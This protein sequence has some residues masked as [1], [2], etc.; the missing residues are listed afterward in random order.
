[1]MPLQLFANANFTGTN[2]LTF[3][4]YA[5]LGAGVLFLSLNLVQVQGYNQLQSGLTFLPFTLLMIFNA[6]LAGSLSDKYG[7]RLF[8]TGGPLIAGIGLLLLSFVQQ[9]KG[10]SG[11]WTSFFPGILVLG[12]GMSLTV[13]PL[14]S[15]VMGSVS[16]HFSGTASGVNNAISRIANV[17]VNAIFGALAVLLFSAATQQ[18]LKE[19]P[20]CLMVMKISSTR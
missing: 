2:L 13:A 10:P 1:M 16:D 5:A 3:F 4:L 7:S 20:N 8:L 17:F 19:L 18:Q 9:T 14:T 12:L 6:R 11:Y 15:T